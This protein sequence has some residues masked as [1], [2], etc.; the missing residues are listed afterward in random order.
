MKTINYLGLNVDFVNHEDYIKLQKELTKNKELVGEDKW[1][2]RVN[3]GEWKDGGKTLYDFT[4]F[5]YS[6]KT[7]ESLLN[8]YK[9][10]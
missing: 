1:I 6:H 5:L 10:Q 4:G 3:E 9:T 7:P 2:Y 8:Y